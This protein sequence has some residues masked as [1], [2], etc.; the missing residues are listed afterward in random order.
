MFV[1]G[2]VRCLSSRFWFAPLEPC[3]QLLCD[4]CLGFDLLLLGFDVCY[5]VGYCGLLL[6]GAAPRGKEIFRVVNQCY[7]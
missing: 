1:G 2:E 3:F 7:V 5:D 4:S 6:L